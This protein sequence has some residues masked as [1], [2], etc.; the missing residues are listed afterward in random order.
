MNTTDTIVTAM[1]TG[2]LAALVASLVWFLIFRLI[3]PRIRIAPIGTGDPA[4]GWIR[5]K[6]LNGSR[7]DLIDLRFELDVMRPRVSP[8][9]VTYGR[10]RVSLAGPAP[11]IIAGRGRPD[12][13]NAYRVAAQLDP[14][15]VFTKDRAYFVRFR[16]FGRDALSGVGRVIEMRYDTLSTFV[17]GEY[18]K[19][20]TF[21]IVRDV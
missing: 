17:E 20:Q 1:W 8:R 2:I 15:D 4:T 14:T 9:G 5:I 16:V 13:S 10:S 3:R 21:Q 11:V 18:E 6:V 12:D 19:G 7:R